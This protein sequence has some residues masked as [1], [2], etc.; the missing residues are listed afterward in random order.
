VENIKAGIAKCRERGLSSNGKSGFTL[1]W[2]RLI[3]LAD[4]IRFFA[5]S[6][7]T[8]IMVFEGYQK[9]A[10]EQAAAL[11]AGVEAE[12]WF[13]QSIY[14]TVDRLRK[15]C[16]TLGMGASIQRMGML[17]CRLSGQLKTNQCPYEVI[18]SEIGGLLHAVWAELAERHFAFVPAESAR[19]FE[20]P[21]LFGE[22]VNKAFP[23]AVDEIRDAGNCLAVGLQTAAVFHC[24]RIAEHGLRALAGHLKIKVKHGLKYADWGTITQGMEKKLDVLQQK[25]RGKRK[26][27]ALEF[28]RLAMDDCNMFKDVWR[29]NV[30]HTRGRYSEAEALGV[31]LRVHGFMQRLA[32]RNISEVK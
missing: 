3:S 16:V 26:A 23:S 5:Q 9:R 31:H 24:M 4:M 30:M 27:E 32:G 13:K 2:K 7:V 15:H 10:E 8:E 29:N 22:A 28:Y 6:L 14:E 20:Q 25:S 21:A 1:D 18:D 12:G 11:G 17:D 19:Y